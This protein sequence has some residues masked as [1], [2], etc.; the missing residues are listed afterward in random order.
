MRQITVTEQNEWEG[1]TFSYIVT[2]DDQTIEDIKTGL[3]KYKNVKI[4]ENT[5]FTYEN[6][7]GLNDSSSNSYMDRYQFNVLVLPEGDFDWYY[8]VFYKATGLGRD[9][10]SKI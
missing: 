2:V 3:V 5:T 7:V 9:T 8:D 10:S 1:E 6:I 4:V